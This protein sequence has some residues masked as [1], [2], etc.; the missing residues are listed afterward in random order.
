M[1]DNGLANGLATLR[2][3]VMDL[4]ADQARHINACSTRLVRQQALRILV[5]LKI[6]SKVDRSR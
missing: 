3:S 4:V 2:G 1:T 6:I 5:R